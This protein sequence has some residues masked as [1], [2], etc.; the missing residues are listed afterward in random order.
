MFQYKPLPDSAKRDKPKD[1]LAEKVTKPFKPITAPIMK[2]YNKGS[3]LKGIGWLINITGKV[4][5]VV[6]ITFLLIA[7]IATILVLS[8]AAGQFASDLSG[9]PDV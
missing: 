8:I 1:T 9:G 6:L 3:Q 4:L 7:A 5:M 2:L